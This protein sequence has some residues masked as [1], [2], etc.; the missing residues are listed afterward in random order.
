MLTDLFVHFCRLR[1][2]C[3]ECEK[4][5]H[6]HGQVIIRL[7]DATH[8]LDCECSA[9]TFLKSKA[10]NACEPHSLCPAGMGLTEHGQLIAHGNNECTLPS[11][12]RCS[13]DKSKLFK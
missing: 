1:D 6:V 9:G 4:E 3:I 10:D 13:Y 2:E 8:N 5:C 11:P 12:A 7:C